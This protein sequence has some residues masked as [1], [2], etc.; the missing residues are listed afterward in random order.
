MALHFEFGDLP[1]VTIREAFQLIVEMEYRKLAV[2]HGADAR[3]AFKFGPGE[4]PLLEAVDQITEINEP[5]HRPA[6]LYG[7]W[8]A[9]LLWAEDK[10][11]YL[12]SDGGPNDHTN[13]YPAYDS[14]DWNVC[15]R[16]WPA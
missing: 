12:R 10:L 5:Q 11:I 8:Y 4:T 1:F 16:K 13:L 7:P 6:R 14:Q 2:A 9:N 3:Y 15:P